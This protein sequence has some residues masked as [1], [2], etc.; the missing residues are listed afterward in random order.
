MLAEIA[1]TPIDKT[2]EG[3]STYVAQSIK[4]IKASGLAY[5]MTPMGTII[6]GSADD[7]FDLIKAV[8]KNMA[9]QSDRVST[10]IKI[11]DRKG[12]LDALSGKIKSV[13]AALG[14][15]VKKV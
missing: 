8:H 3:F 2:Q 4:M 15:N 9:S 1:V 14:E 7:V 13:E 6:E 10:S 12:V 11:D 5:V